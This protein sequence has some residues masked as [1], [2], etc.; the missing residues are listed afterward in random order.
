MKHSEIKKITSIFTPSAPIDSKSRF[1]GRKS[2]QKL[3]KR[4]LVAP[5]RHIILYGERGVGKTSLLN[6]ISKEMK[7]S[8]NLNYCV[9][10]CAHGDTYNDIFGSYLRETNQLKET[11]A[12][13]VKTIRNLDSRLKI[14]AVEGGVKAVTEKEYATEPVIPALYTPHVLVTKFCTKPFLFVIDEFDRISSN[15]TKKTI[16]ETIKILADCQSP[17]K[18]VIS[19]VSDSAIE[20]TGA[21]PS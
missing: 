20:L 16:A 19:G 15:D 8:E 5:G 13:K 4:S 3:F 11:N 10:R 1:V 21:H 18:I 7:K 9:Y 17:T 12:N 2:E 6:I 14:L